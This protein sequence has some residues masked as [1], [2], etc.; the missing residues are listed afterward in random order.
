MGT[1]LHDLRFAVKLLQKS[2][3]F[4]LV[5]VL[6]LAL[7]IAANT[8]V[9]TGVN[10]VLL[11]PLPYE[12]PDRLVRVYTEFPRQQ[13]TK[14]YL[15]A[16]EYFDLARE[17]RAFDSMGAWV[18]AT[19]NLTGSDQPQSV[20]RSFF[21]AS[22]LST[23]GVKPALGRGFSAEEDVP[24]G[25]QV[26]LISYELWQRSFWG[27]LGVLG[28]TVEVNGVSTTV[29]GVMPKGFDFP[30]NGA[31]LWSPLALDPAAGDDVRASHSYNVIARTKPGVTVDAANADLKDLATAWSAAHPQLHYPDPLLH[32]MVARSLKGEIVESARPLLWM[33]QGIVFF[34]LLIASV[35]V[36]NLLVARA[37]VRRGEIAVRMALGAGRARLARLFLV[38][39]FVLGVCGAAV[40][41]LV[42]PWALDAMIGLLPEGTPRA[43][44]I[45]I[46]SA[47]LAFAVT[48]A[49]AASLLFGLAPILHTRSSALAEALASA[50]NRATGT[51]RSLLIRRSL[52][53]AEIALAT[54]LVTG[55][56]LFA[57]SFVAL[58]KV[59]PGFV[60]QNAVLFD[61]LVPRA[62][63]P[64]DPSLVRFYE[65]LRDRL[66]R[67]PGVES[68]AGV[69]LPPPRRFAQM[70]DI[71]F[72]GRTPDPKG[73]V[74]NVDY[75][76]VVVGD[77]IEALGG[78]L[79]A[80]RRF[81]P[82]DDEHGQRVALVNEAFVRKFWPGEDAVG[83]HVR[84]IDPTD[85]D[86]TIVGVVG[87]M[88]YAGLDQPTG[89]EIVFPAAQVDSDSKFAQA[90]SVPRNMTF[91]LRTHADPRAV[92][93]SARTAVAAAAPGIPLSR[94][95]TMEDAV[96][97]DVAQPRLLTALVLGFAGI[98][99]VM[100]LVGV[101][102]VMSYSIVQRSREI[103][104]RIAL[105]APPGRV[106]GMLLRQGLALAGTGIA[107]GQALSFAL[108]RVLAHSLSGLLFGPSSLDA[109]MVTAV[110]GA[111][112][113]VALLACYVPARRASGI[114]PM[115]SM[116]VEA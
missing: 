62:N 21:T 109:A 111:L 81:S 16:P 93:A 2:T 92:F 3:A 40:G 115:T 116:R 76:Q 15:S 48:S 95:R 98:A 82:G 85:P 6:T 64:D 31:Q 53:V 51:K 74:W 13:L 99:L 87:D 28:K 75:W 12:Q 101:Y 4:T 61:L 60:P 110:V 69:W 44:E 79:V 24:G 42:T 94:M 52:V 88:K 54:V 17:T 34:V 38:E 23:L 103:G 14:F 108:Q 58:Q 72:P 80:G 77:H 47:V 11:Q 20:P 35:N 102:G 65:D 9:F 43:H 63:V 55:A 37:D 106:V 19:A 90:A 7:A 112:G 1:L 18:S 5:S 113:A 10:A 50:A 70:N 57:R 105:G 68:A 100:A 89:S 30:G 78:R 39:S 66:A 73:P 96:F 25:A 107:V 104:I 33:L 91:V 26:V 41:L 84:A 71:W 86:L 83:K 22:A 114:H 49:L 45:R 36:S 8:V 32:P 46:D 29:I 56:G 59:D 67:I 97:D 27:D